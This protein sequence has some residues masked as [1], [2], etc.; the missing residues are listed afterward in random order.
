MKYIGVAIIFLSVFLIVRVYRKY[1]DASTE[2]VEGFILFVR[3]M[4]SRISC[5]LE[6][7]SR[8]A[9]NFRNDALE[10]VGFLSQLRE[11]GSLKDAWDSV[12]NKVTLPP[13]VKRSLK[14]L[15]SRTGGG[16]LNDELKILEDTEASLVA[17]DG[18]ERGAT[19][20][21][22]KLVTTVLFALSAGLALLI[23]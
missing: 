14:D 16:Y 11:H 9:S 19:G 7:P 12:E 13:D 10:E 21:R 18:R 15:F 20:E 6:P 17:A 22:G 8:W 3:E 23:I 2:L 5:Y 4:R 1:L